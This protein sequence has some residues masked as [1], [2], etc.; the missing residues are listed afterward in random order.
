MKTVRV[1]Q[2]ISE[3]IIASLKELGNIVK[4]VLVDEQNLMYLI[5]HYVPA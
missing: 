3:T 1:P 4:S 2:E 5:I